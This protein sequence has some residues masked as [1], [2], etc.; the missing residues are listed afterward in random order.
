MSN[1]FPDSVQQVADII[2]AEAALKLVRQWPRTNASST[3]KGRV[4]LYVP[5]TLPTGHTLV[6]ILGEDVAQ[7]FVRHFGGELLFLAACASIRTRETHRTILA[8]MNAGASPIMAA[9]VFGISPQHARR[10]RNANKAAKDAVATHGHDSRMN[11]TA[12]HA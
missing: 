1:T 6:D 4:V 5:T 8:A 7:K 12:N 3:T 9:R 10:I 11:V 2:G